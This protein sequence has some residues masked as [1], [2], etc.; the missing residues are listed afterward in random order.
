MQAKKINLFK[1]IVHG[2]LAV[3]LLL[4]ATQAFSQAQSGNVYGKVTDEQGQPLPGVS[5]TL[6]GKI[7]PLSTVSNSQG[8][9]RFLNLDPGTYTLTHSLQGFSTVKRDGVIVNVAKN[10]ELAFTMKLSNVAAEVIVTDEAPLLDTRKVSTGATISQVELSSIPTARDP[11]VILQSVPGVLMDRVNV[12]GNESGQQSNYVAKGSSGSAST[13]NVDGVNITDVGAVGSSPTYYDFDSF[14]EMQVS[15]G[16]SDVTLVTAGASLNMVTKRGTNDVHGSARVF[17]TD[18]RWQADTDNAEAT[19]Q[20]FQRGNRIDDIQ[21]YGFEVGGPVVKDRLWLWGSYGRNQI[22][23][24]TPSSAAA[25]QGFSDKTTLEDINAK[26]NGQITDNNSATLFYLRGDKIKLGR[27]AGT[28]RPQE[29][30]WDQK[31]PSSLY[32]IEDS[33]IFS[34]NLFATALFS[35]V[36]GGFSFTPQ[37]G[38]TPFAFRTPDG[39]NHGTY[40]F[41]ESG[42]PQTQLSGSANAFARTG[43]VGHEFKLGFVYRKAPVTSNLAWPH[44]FRSINRN[45]SASG[46]S[47]SEVRIYKTMVAPIDS[48]FYSGYL[49]DT[50]TIKNL[51]VNVGVRYDNQAG[52]LAAATSTANETFP[53]VFPS[54]SQ[55]EAD[56]PF[57]WKNVSPRVGLTYAL[58]KNAADKTLIRA[59][60]GRFVDNM[61]GGNILFNSSTYYG[62]MAYRFTDLNGD[63]VAQRSEV[64]FNNIVYAYNVDP[65]NP[66]ARSPN[67]IDPNFKSPTTDEFVLGAEREVLP[68]IAV[69]VN[70]TYRKY[71]NFGWTPSYGLVNGQMHVFTPSDFE[72]AGTVAGTTPSGAAYNV[73]YYGLKSTAPARVGRY[74][75]NRPDYSQ[76]YKGV[77]LQITKRYSNN[78]SFRGSFSYNDWTQNVG[79]GAISDP[80]NQLSTAIYGGNAGASSEDGGDVVFSGGVNS[81][82]KGGIYINSKWQ[83]NM[84]ALYS[85]PLGFNV[86]ANFFARQGYPRV[87]I[88]SSADAGDGFGAR[89][90]LIQNVTAERHPTVTSLDFRVD[91]S[92]KVASLN[93]TLSIDLFNAFNSN[94]ILQRQTDVQQTVAP[95]GDIQEIQ[96]PRV[97]RFGGRVSF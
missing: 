31:G 35:R 81:G 58:G 56:A 47:R 85:L 41:Y 39:V 17:A 24:R 68:G 7:A 36:I 43:E 53:D 82:A 45:P 69:S 48:R 26:M 21:D 97:V 16:G 90:A 5:V 28:T 34:A 91:K 32:K 62:Y 64:D 74:L 51:T 2:F 93:I 12:G 72:V 77:E 8:E 61:G 23:L 38:S 60:Y 63:R 79:A 4:G 42:R 22:N 94:V 52:N 84:N 73:P 25:P 29:T 78:W 54:I 57:T 59:S 9:Y 33:H 96:S 67:R 30:T 15:T 1:G 40:Y 89:N 86:A 19:A 88:D 13:W 75:T 80:T 46:A 76:D 20:G 92:V 70:G 95:A 14:Q 66:A 83:L 3:A 55:A 18:K 50:L 71:R 44:G 10:T 65:S 11:W 49:S 87:F 27:N 37:G 6:S